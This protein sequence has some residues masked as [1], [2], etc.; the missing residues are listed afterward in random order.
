MQQAVLNFSVIIKI[1]YVTFVMKG[2]FVNFVA[3]VGTW[4][5]WPEEQEAVENKRVE[6]NR[7]SREVYSTYY[8]V[9]CAISLKVKFTSFN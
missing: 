2:R 4:F 7:G 6:V 3:L 5:L 1:K 8:H 9:L